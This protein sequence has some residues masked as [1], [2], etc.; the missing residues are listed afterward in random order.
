[1]DCSLR[2]LC[3]NLTKH[4]TSVDRASPRQ[5]SDQLSSRFIPEDELPIGNVL[6]IDRQ[7]A[8]LIR[9]SSARSPINDLDGNLSG[10]VEGI[11]A[12][13]S[14]GSDGLSRLS[15][16]LVDEEVSV[17]RMAAKATDDGGNVDS[18]CSSKNDASF[19]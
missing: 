17:G 4:L 8:Q 14:K 18:V 12:G 19:C 2:N 15:G 10:Q 7:F 6:E 13:R 16:E 9:T 3:D 5:R 1:M 11:G